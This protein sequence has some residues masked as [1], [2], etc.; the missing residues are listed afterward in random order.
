MQKLI[1]I[2]L[3]AAFLSLVILWVGCG[4][5]KSV[6]IGEKT[7][8]PEW[9]INIP[10]NPDYFYAAAT[11]RSKDL[12]FAVDMAKNNTR[13][14]LS[15]QLQTRIS[16]LF[17]QFREQTGSPEDAEFIE[18]ASSV[19][20]AVVSEAINGAKVSKQEVKEKD[21]LYEAYVLMEMP[22][23]EANT[24]LM[25]KVKAN[26]N[27]YTRFRASQGFKELEED[28]EKYEQW[29]KEQGL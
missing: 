25:A 17:K 10:S 23:G 8:V 5:S 27:L 18:Q 3:I 9:Y 12:Q 7:S 16:A 28:V 19:S 4:G 21:K 14:D 26:Q 11:A 20:K 13:V 24:A 2:S 22:V 1:G 6:P 15:Q 29:K